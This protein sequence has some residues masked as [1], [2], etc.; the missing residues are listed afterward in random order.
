MTQASI[1]ENMPEHVYH[2]DPCEAPS[3]SSHTAH[4]IIS[5]TPLHAW[6]NHPR[7]G[8]AP[9]EPKKEFDKGSL[10]HCLVLQPRWRELVE[11][12]NADAWRTNASKDARKRAWEEL[13]VPVLTKHFDQAQEA[14]AAIVR[15]LKAHGVELTGR[16]EETFLWYAKTSTGE[17]VACRSRLDHRI[18]PLIIELKTSNSA[19]P[20][21]CARHSYDYGYHIQRTAYVH[22]VEQAYPEFTGRVRHRIFFAEADPPYCLTPAELTAEFVELGEHQWQRGV[23]IWHRCLTTDKWPQ[24]TSGVARLEPPMWALRDEMEREYDTNL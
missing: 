14:A 9:R 13:K 24:Y 21:I 17:P 3:L 8:G 15:Q 23:D 4:T 19:H 20:R 10:L 2:S 12:V 22:A 16:S 11:V 7:L 1:V 5:Q 18:G 6:F